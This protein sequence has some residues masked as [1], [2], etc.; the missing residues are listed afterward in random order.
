MLRRSMLRM[1]D[2]EMKCAALYI[3]S[4]LPKIEISEKKA[5]PDSSHSSDITCQPDEDTAHV[6]DALTVE[7]FQQVPWH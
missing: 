4:I 2:A 7:S 6:R 5:A 1:N 3:F